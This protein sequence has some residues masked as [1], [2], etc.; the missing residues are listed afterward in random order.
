[1]KT[2]SGAR[3]ER[4]VLTKLLAQLEK[5]DVLMT[6]RLGRSPAHL[7]KRCLLVQLGHASVCFSS[8]HARISSGSIV[9]A[10]NCQIT[11]VN[12]FI[13]GLKFCAV[14]RPILH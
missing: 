8:R 1:M 2:A 13:R 9:S 5:G 12:P 4:P 14:L 11:A 3:H 6:F 7:V 10:M